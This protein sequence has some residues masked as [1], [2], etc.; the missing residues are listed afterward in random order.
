MRWV[1]ATGV[2]PRTKAEK[3]YVKY[4]NGLVSKQAYPVARQRWSHIGQDWDIV[5]YFA[6]EEAEADDGAWRA[7]SGGY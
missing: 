3:V 2:Q 5:A 6:T 4:R 7:V 1:R